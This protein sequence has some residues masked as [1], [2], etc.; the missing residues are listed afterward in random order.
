MA[1]VALIILPK[2]K[3]ILIINGRKIQ[4]PFENGCLFCGD[5][6]LLVGGFNPF[7]KY[8]R[9]NGNLPQIGMNIKNIWN[10]HLDNNKIIIH[11]VQ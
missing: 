2:K 11:N 10:H 8:D 5:I 7:E 1:K 3:N 9:Q 6:H 4:F